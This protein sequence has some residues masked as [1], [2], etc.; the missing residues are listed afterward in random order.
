[1]SLRV[2][3]IPEV[4]EETARVAR[5]AFP[6]GNLYMKMRDELGT[7]YQDADFAD[8]FPTC[9]QPAYSPW[10]LALITVMQFAEGLS[11]RQAAEA[12]RAR[13]DWKYAL[14]L[15]L[16]DSGFDFSIL[17][18]FRSRLLEKSLESLLLDNVLERFRVKGWL[19]AGGR[20]RTDSTHILA[21]VR[22]LNRLESLGETLRAAL[23]EIAKVAPD[24][25]EKRVPEEWF[26]R[27]SRRIE[28]YRLPKGEQKRYE[29]AVV[30]GQDGYLLLSEIDQKETPLQ[31]KQ[32]ESVNVLRQ[33]W[34]HQYTTEKNKVRL[35]TGK[36]LLPAGERFDSPYDPEAHFGNKRAITWHGY[37]VHLTETCDEE[38][39]HLITQVETTSSVIPDVELGEKIQTDLAAKKL[40]PKEHLVDAGYVDAQWL[41]ESRE[42]LAVEVIGPVREDIQWQAKTGSG[43]AL[44]DFSIDWENRRVTC[45]AG[46]T[47]KNWYSLKKLTGQDWI[48]IRFNRSQCGGCLQRIN[49][50]KAKHERSLL[51]REQNQ[52]EALQKR[53]SEQTTD[54]WKKRYQARAGIEGTISQSVRVCDIRHSR[55]IGQSKTHLQNVA[56]ASAINILRSGDWLME[57]PQA[58]T[59]TSHFAKLAITGH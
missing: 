4:P 14:S 18:E 29:Y 25:L 51:I 49:C 59:R 22:Q 44:S 47:T 6:K 32:L 41:A 23:N 50:T 52:H 13:I 20:Q 2:K 40:L 53:R 24:W 56:T 7:F 57:N 37:K 39:V 8:L 5:A 48:R 33:M 3:P 19:K 31:I 11:D 9:G 16:E 54:E 15:E 43:F 34:E 12:V 55:Y 35:R 46:K 27:Y 42:R 38:G 17:S 58:K 21:K 28:E 1:M 45:P 30:I 36:E 10:R 26:R